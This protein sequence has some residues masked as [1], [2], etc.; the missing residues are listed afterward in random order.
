MKNKKPPVW[1]NRVLDICIYYADYLKE[2]ADRGLISA[3]DAR[4]QGLLEIANCNTKSAAIKKAKS[5]AE[6][7]L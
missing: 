5:L 7:I 6:L 2:A 3:E 4:W 1:I